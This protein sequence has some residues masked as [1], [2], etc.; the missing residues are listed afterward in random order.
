MSTISE[1]I[2]QFEQG[3]GL[4]VSAIGTATSVLGFGLV[5]CLAAWSASSQI[6]AAG[7]NQINARAFWFRIVMS[8]VIATACAGVFA[9]GSPVAG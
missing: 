1:M 9:V 2:A 3:S 4:T 8:M 7:N 5:F 6:G